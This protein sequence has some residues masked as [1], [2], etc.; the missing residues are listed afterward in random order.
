[1]DHPILIEN[2]SS[3]YNITPSNL[4]HVLDNFKLCSGIDATNV[5]NSVNISRHI[6]PMQFDFSTWKASDGIKLSTNQKEYLRSNNCCLL[7][8]LNAETTCNSCKKLMI[9][10]EIELRRKISHQTSP[11]SPKAPVSLTSPERL[12]ATLQQQRAVIKEQSKECAQLQQQIKDLQE[13]LEKNSCT[14]DDSLQSDLK[15]IFEGK[16][17]YFF[18]FVCS[19]VFSEEKLGVLKSS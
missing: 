9:S 10:T 13:Q 16:D 12:K 18:V 5:M 4:I 17:K 7:V 11:V 19:I 2:Q 15:D 3:F 14:V 1:M 8:K 6:I